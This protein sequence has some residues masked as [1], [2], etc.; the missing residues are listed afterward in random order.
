[1]YWSLRPDKFSQTCDKTKSNYFKKIFKLVDYSGADAN[2]TQV[3][4]W[5]RKLIKPRLHL[6]ADANKT[7]NLTILGADANTT[8]IQFYYILWIK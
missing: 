5:A 2:T 4:V 1:M 6:G 3:K 8:W 7:W